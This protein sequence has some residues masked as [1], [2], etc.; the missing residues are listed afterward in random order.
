M[1]NMS[2]LIADSGSTKTDWCL[3][4][5]Q[6]IKKFS[7]QGINPYFQ[8]AG[9]IKHILTREI[10][11]SIQS[12]QLDQIHFYGAG[13]N[14]TDHQS[15]IKNCLQSVLTAKKINTYS[16]MMASA[17]ATCGKTKGIACILGTGSNT[18]LYTGK[19]I[20]FKT[21]SLGYIL[22]DEGGGTYLGKKVL[23]YFLHEIFDEELMLS[24]QHTFQT[25]MTEILENI[26]RKPLPNRYLAQYAQFIFQHRGH[27]MIENIAEDCIN[28]LFIHHLI[29][30]P[31]VQRIPIHFTGSVA[32]YLRD[33]ISATC[34]Q[35]N[36]VMGKVIQKPMDGLIT[37]YRAQ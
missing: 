22:G 32:Y 4:R 35:Y 36:L 9:E 13:I 34:E 3:I 11:K 19:K 10:P 1:D 5:H 24:F 26:Y 31:G 6:K 12:V 29:R 8:L 16:D 2:I 25:N 18:C 30:Y 21:P 27:Y 14:S 17:H 7:T 37:Y 20:S 33:L 23:Q 28:D 15:I